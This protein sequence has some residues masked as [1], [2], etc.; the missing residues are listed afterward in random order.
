MCS[1]IAR[2]AAAAI[3]FCLWI[4]S[5]ETSVA[6][7]QATPAQKPAAP[8]A[9]PAAPPS[10]AAPDAAKRRAAPPS[11]PALSGVVNINT[12]TA[13]ELALLPG[14][15]PAKARAILA[16]RQA[17]G[18]FKKVDDLANVKGIGDGNL[19][20]LRP[21]CTVEGKTTARPTGS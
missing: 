8:T 21:F 6:W 11:A 15:G 4:G 5:T 20:R 9:V 1:S 3:L 12:A 16:Y 10:A 13:E 2:R 19:A 7:A 14:V 17:Q 18:P